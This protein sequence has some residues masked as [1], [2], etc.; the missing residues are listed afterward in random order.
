M[1]NAGL[2]LE[3]MSDLDTWIAAML[4]A[5]ALFIVWVASAPKRPAHDVAMVGLGFALLAFAVGIML[6]AL[7]GGA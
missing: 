4:L 3:I 2:M 7:T 1:S 6:R 5:V